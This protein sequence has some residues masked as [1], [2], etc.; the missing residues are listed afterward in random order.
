MTELG[1]KKATHIQINH[2]IFLYDEVDGVE[3]VSYTGL[4]DASDPDTF[5][6]FLTQDRFLNNKA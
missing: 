5:D 1:I 4:I 3:N 2:L 6:T